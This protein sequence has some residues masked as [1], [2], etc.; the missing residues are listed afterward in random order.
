MT[1]DSTHRVTLLPVLEEILGNEV[2][3][4]ATSREG[5]DKTC[6]LSARVGMIATNN[7]DVKPPY[8][9][10]LA[11]PELWLEMGRPLEIVATSFS[12]SGDFLIGEIRKKHVGKILGLVVW[13]R[14]DDYGSR[15][16]REENAVT[17]AIQIRKY[18]F[19]NH[20]TDLVVSYHNGLIY[21]YTLTNLQQVMGRGILVSQSIGM[22]PPYMVVTQ[23]VFSSDGNRLVIANPGGELTIRDGEKDYMLEHCFPTGGTW[24]TSLAIGMNDTVIAKATTGRIVELWNVTSGNLEQELLIAGL[25]KIKR[26]L[27][28]SPNGE[29]LIAIVRKTR[30]EF[31][32]CRVEGI[33]YYHIPSGRSHATMLTDPPTLV[34]CDNMHIWCM[35]GDQLYVF[36]LDDSKLQTVYKFPPNAKNVVITRDKSTVAYCLNDNKVC[37]SPL[38][39]VATESA[40][41]MVATGPND[42][43]QMMSM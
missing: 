24:A 18:A 33:W 41:P 2:A 15:V 16:I 4:L 39:D 30:T 42:L 20:T 38:L 40:E 22:G 23:M 1:I 13:C 31:G 8:L 7:P 14:E 26:C 32:T 21:K 43:G 36:S 25:Y 10:N 6:T 9:A 12:P 28:F 35:S 34:D 27:Q 19:S 11:I 37:V 5:Y 29:Y 3:R 17:H